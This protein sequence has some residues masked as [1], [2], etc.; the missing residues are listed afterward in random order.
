VDV[1]GWREIILPLHVPIVGG[2]WCIVPTYHAVSLTQVLGAQRAIE[3]RQEDLFG[4]AYEE[5]ERFAPPVVEIALDFT[6]GL[7]MVPDIIN[8]CHT[9]LLDVT[10]MKVDCA[11]ADG[12]VSILDVGATHWLHCA[13]WW[14]D[15]LILE[16]VMR[17]DLAVSIVMLGVAMLGM[18][19]L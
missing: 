8:Q 18:A 13:L 11:G 15:I 3:S 5:V 7:L 6:M 12:V 19:T 17:S 16:V 10:A 14:R 9:G 1:Q 2:T 4:D